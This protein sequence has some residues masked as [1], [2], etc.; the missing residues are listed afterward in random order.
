MYQVLR[1]GEVAS[2]GGAGGEGRG[3]GSVHWGTLEAA[4]RTFSSWSVGCEGR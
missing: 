1:E 2:V 3:A 4:V